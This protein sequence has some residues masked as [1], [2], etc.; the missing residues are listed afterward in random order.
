VHLLQNT[1]FFWRRAHVSNLQCPRLSIGVPGTLH[2]ANSIEGFK[3][4]DKR[5][6][7]EQQTGAVRVNYDNIRLHHRPCVRSTNKTNVADHSAFAGCR[8]GRTSRMVRR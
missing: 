5:A 8:Y 3:L 4:Y 1:P 2:L 6:L 7:L